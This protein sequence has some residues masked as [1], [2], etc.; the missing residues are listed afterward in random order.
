M[1][2][3]DHRHHRRAVGISNHGSQIAKKKK[4][5]FEYSQ[6]NHFTSANEA[7]LFLFFFWNL[8]TPRSP[9]SNDRTNIYFDRR[10]ILLD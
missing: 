5:V 2:N 6:I 4:I 3:I 9:V 10:S 1:R 7:R 8:S